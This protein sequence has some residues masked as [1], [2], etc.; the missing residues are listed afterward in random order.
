MTSKPYGMMEG[1]EPTIIGMTSAR[2]TF[3]ERGKLMKTRIIAA[4][5]LSAVASIALSAGMATTALADTEA[6]FIKASGGAQ[7]FEINPIKGSSAFDLDGDGKADTIG[8]KY[9][10]NPDYSDSY[11]MMTMSIAGKSVKVA[12][13]DFFFEPVVT[14]VKTASGDALISIN[15]SSENDYPAIQKV[16]RYKNGTITEA[17]NC[18]DQ[19][20]VLQPYGHRPQM[21]LAGVSGDKLVVEWSCQFYTCG[22]TTFKYSYK[23]DTNTGKYVAPKGKATA[24]T[25]FIKGAPSYK[26]TTWSKTTKAVQTY[27]NATCTKKAKKVVKGTKAKVVGFNLS[28]KNVPTLKIKTKSGYE[29]YVKLSKSQKWDVSTGAFKATIFKNVVFAG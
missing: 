13:K 4:M 28:A 8:F 20:N 10:E 3:P 11:T 29:S 12:Q 16:Y 7:V 24:K 14:L 25:R 9:A 1:D 27:K 6:G 19:Q 22:L 17:L 2:T 21:R 5:G 18:M 23:L 15:A 26:S